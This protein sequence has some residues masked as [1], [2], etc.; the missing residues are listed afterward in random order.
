VLP[1]LHPLLKQIMLAQRRAFS[2]WLLDTISIFFAV[3]VVVFSLCAY[4]QS[5]LMGKAMVNSE[6]ESVISLALS[7]A[8]TCKD[9][10]SFGSL[11]VNNSIA[12]N[13]C[14]KSDPKLLMTL[15]YEGMRDVSV[16]ANTSEMTEWCGFRTW[17]AACWGI[18]ITPVIFAV[19]DEVVLT[20]LHVYMCFMMSRIISGRGVIMRNKKGGLDED[21]VAF[22]VKPTTA[23]IFFSLGIVNTL[24]V[25]MHAAQLTINGSLLSAPVPQPPPEHIVLP[26]YCYGKCVDYTYYY[27]TFNIATAMVAGTFE[28]MPTCN[29]WCIFIDN[30]NNNDRLALRG[31]KRDS[32]MRQ[33]QSDLL[34][35]REHVML[36]QRLDLLDNR[37][38][39][40]VEQLENTL[41]RTKRKRKY[42][43]EEDEEEEDQE[44]APQIV[45]RFIQ[46]KEMISKDVTVAT[47]G[48]HKMLCVEDAELRQIQSEGVLAIQ[49]EVDNFGNAE[50]SELLNYIL[51][52]KCSPKK[53]ENGIRDKGH[54]GWSLQ[55]FMQSK[56]VETGLAKA[57]VVALRLCK[58][59][60]G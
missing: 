14:P 43:D 55:D 1:V 49:K 42:D 52:E 40:Q 30:R 46:S 26:S 58:Y 20:S 37:V 36:M 27:F 56:E 15:I 21:S 12:E 48:L 51:H 41:W 44:V 29:C 38:K 47:N 39:N 54:E 11:F 32:S 3:S 2:G 59:I 16:Q 34:T 25:I 35:I 28:Y 57:H 7:S 50:V 22:L 60:I 13:A 5:V 19:R 10:L 23:W 9:A 4:A 18:G 24:I 33:N 8:F 17:S 53:Y 31:L 45:T 6:S